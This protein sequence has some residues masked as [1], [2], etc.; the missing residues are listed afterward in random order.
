MPINEKTGKLEEVKE[1]KQVKKTETKPKKE[2]P[3]KTEEKGF[4][5]HA[6][7][8]NLRSE[9]SMT[10]RIRTILKENDAVDIIDVSGDF[11]FVRTEHL[12]EGYV[13][14]DFIERV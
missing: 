4:I 2:P 9:P 6:A 12:Q 5:A 10:S 7:F 13:Q 3:I 11:Y 1:K 14:K 8:V